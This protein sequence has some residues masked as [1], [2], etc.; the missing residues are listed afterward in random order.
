MFIILF[1]VSPHSCSYGDIF[2]DLTV[3]HIAL[4]L[5]HPTFRENTP[6]KHSQDAI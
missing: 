1:Y 2:F 3:Q 4:L 6:L 5:H